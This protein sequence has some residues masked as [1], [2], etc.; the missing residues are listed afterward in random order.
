MSYQLAK[1]RFSL[2]RVA[3]NQCLISRSALRLT[4][5][6]ACLSTCCQPFAQTVT[7]ALTGIPI[8]SVASS[9]GGTKLVAGSDSRTSSGS[10]YTSTNSGATWTMTYP[11]GNST[12][13]AIASSADGTKLVAASASHLFTSTNSGAEWS[14]RTDWYDNWASVASSTDGTRLAAGSLAYGGSGRIYTSSDSGGA[15]KLATTPKNDW[16]SIATSADGRKLVAAAGWFALSTKGGIYTSTNWGDTWT[17]TTAPSNIWSSLASSADGTKLAAAAYRSDW[18]STP[19]GGIY[20]STDSGVTWQPAPGDAFMGYSSWTGVASSGDG[21]RLAALSEGGGLMISTN[22]GALWSGTAGFGV[23]GVFGRFTSIASSVDGT[24]FLIGCESVYNSM[25]LP[26]LFI[27]TLSSPPPPLIITGGFTSPQ[28]PF[29]LGFAGDTNASYHMVAA[30][31][32]ALPPSSWTTLGTST[33]TNGAHQFI[34]TQATNYSKRFYRVT[35][36]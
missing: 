36:P 34:D 13:V 24:Q 11:G 33:V 29:L 32:P 14:Q 30:T 3:S 8:Y 2:P 35:S 20:V 4:V 7:R 1:K 21:T 27:Y 10:I 28:G 23:S 15:W 18:A 9:S 31:D 6:M 5:V 17:E 16:S 19:P 12:W 25:S 22:S 26:G